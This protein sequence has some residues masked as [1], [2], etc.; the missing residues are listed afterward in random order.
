MAKFFYNPEDPKTYER[1]RLPNSSFHRDKYARM[2]RRIPRDSK[3]RVL[4][5]G[6]GTG[7]YTKFLVKDFNTVV[8]TD[9]DADMCRQTKTLVPEAEAQ[10]ADACHLPFKDRSFDGVF[11]VSILHHVPDRVQAFREVARVLKPGGWFAFCEPN[12]LNPFSLLVQTYFREPALTF[13]GMRR[14]ARKAGL[15]VSDGGEILFR[16]PRVS[17]VTDRIP[18]WKFVER[19]VE[20]VHLGVSVY[21]SGRK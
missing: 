5:I 8:A 10:V 12:A 6:A 7:I 9:A 20:L 3:Q 18:G 4:E 17:P 14:D 16:S 11:G 13:N 21:V 15:F 2:M 19:A 1:F